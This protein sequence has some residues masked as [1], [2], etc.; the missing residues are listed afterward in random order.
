[1]KQN[2]STAE[3]AA[4]NASHDA[5]GWPAARRVLEQQGDRG[6]RERDPDRPAHDD[7]DGV[8][9]LTPIHVV[10]DRRAAHQDHERA[11]RQR[12]GARHQQRRGQV[13]AQER[14]VGLRAVDPVRAALDLRHRRRAGHPCGDRAAHE[15]RL[16]RLL[17]RRTGTL[18]QRLGEDLADRPG[19]ELLDRRPYDLGEGLDVE[20]RGQADDRDQGGSTVRVTWKA[21]ARAWLKPS[22][23]R[24]RAIASRA[25]VRR[26]VCRS[27][28]N[29]SSPS[30]SSR[31]IGT[32]D[33]VVIG[34]GNYGGRRFQRLSAGR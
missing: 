28:S 11:D 31:V 5:S 22:A 19:R 30:S 21:S 14:A 16:A 9:G 24:K 4:P 12:P 7:P 18:A 13:L 15:R 6:D 34:P 8:D 1:M 29:A 25:S 20:R 10:A 2:H 32:V 3:V 27:V 23:A 33:A 17:P 26:P